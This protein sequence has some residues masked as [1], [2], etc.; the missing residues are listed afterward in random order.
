MF[1]QLE[2][3]VF[4]R[5]PGVSCFFEIVRLFL[6]GLCVLAVSP[7]TSATVQF[8]DYHIE[9]G[10]D[11][12][13]ED[14]RG[15]VSLNSGDLDL[16]FDKS[17]QVVGIRFNN[18]DIPPSAEILSA[19]VQF[20][21]GD[22]TNMS[23]ALLIEGEESDDAAAFAR[24]RHNISS[25]SRTGASVIWAPPAW[26]SGGD[27]GSAQR[28]PDL[29]AIVQEI[30]DRPGWKAG[31]SIVLIISGNGKRVAESFNGDAKAAA[32]LHVEFSD[33]QVNAGHPIDAE[34][35]IT[36]VSSENTIF[37]EGVV[38]D[39]DLP[40]GPLSTLWSHVGGTGAGVV[41]FS[42]PGDIHTTVTF[43]GTNV[44]GTYVLRLEAD[45]AQY[46]LPESFQ[47]VPVE[48]VILITSNKEVLGLDQVN[49][50]RTGFDEVSGDPL[51][52]PSIDPAGIAYHPPTDSLFLADSEIEEVL[53]AFETVQANL[54]NT[55]V[56]GGALLDQWD[57]TQQTGN[58]PFLNREPTGVTYCRGDGHFYVSNDD[59]KLIY[60]YTFDGST[61]TAVD[62][63][64]TVPHT[65][66]PEGV[67]C[68][69]DTGRIYVIGGAGINVL[70]YEY[71]S[72]FV[73]L[74]VI[75]LVITAGTP[76]GIP[77][78]PEGIAVDP[79]TGN[80]F[81]IS[82]PDDALFEYTPSGTF[83]QKFPIDSLV[84]APLS[85]Q[86]LVFGRSSAGGKVLSIYIVDALFDNDFDPTER[87]G[88]V[89]ELE[90][91][92]VQ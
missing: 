5:F 58:E 33:N 31:N 34:S 1:D 4:G 64:S 40:A 71:N 50:F 28:T 87:D 23:T 6:I 10:H 81:V 69:P 86:G 18:I 37:L 89:Y 52:I 16:V 85:P 56:E 26:G 44:L 53:P 77:A 57:L 35:A 17:D 2:K 7:G 3:K 20:T 84:P 88:A 59:L 19:T 92:R 65:D 78:N 55:P 68:D 36:L 29:G 75:D 66:D 47:F 43:T 61:F 14:L 82:S 67:A 12:A 30:I 90:V 41:T 72:G 54:F 9:S 63:V 76:S 83:I 42:D 45:D 51:V 13:E 22:A 48:V 74:E 91:Q 27:A 62:S 38:S 73:L 15:R 8:A 24:S 46:D 32:R 80:L 25:R 39:E 60:R 11:D 70:V 79:V 21:A 49:Y